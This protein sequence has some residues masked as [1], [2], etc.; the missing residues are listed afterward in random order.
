MNPKLM[1][2]GGDNTSDRFGSALARKILEQCPQAKLFGVGG[3]LMNDA[4]VRLLYDISEMVSLGVFQSIKGSQVV[5]RL[6]RR[7]VETMEQEQPTLVLQIGL[8]VFGFKILEIARAKGIPV[9]YYYTPLSRGLANVKLSHFPTVVNKVASISRFETSLC[10]EAGIDVQFVGHPLTDLADFSLTPAAARA[11]LGLESADTKVIAILPGAREV[12]VK[13]VLPTILKSLEQVTKQHANI[14]IILSLAQTIRNVFIDDILKDFPKDQVRVERDTYTVLRAADLAI[15]SIG[16]SSL[17]ASLLNVPS[18]A[19]YRVPVTTYFTDKLLDRKPYMTI[20][21]NIL[22]KTVIPEY[23]QGELGI[24][25]IAEAITRLLFDVEARA[26]MLTEFGRLEHE[27][28]APGSVGRA[29]NLIL[30]MAGCV[31]DANPPS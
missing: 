4:G 25:K 15:T 20:T 5:K 7:V 31:N 21:N 1:I 28:G 6:I 23:I 2:I 17:E 13:N 8:P 12:E 19:V 26:E 3:P 18:L 24:T 22:R 27:L 9:V 14:Q 10:E 30:E 16:T 29:A 11:K